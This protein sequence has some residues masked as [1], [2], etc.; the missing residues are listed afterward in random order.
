MSAKTASKPHQF[1][2]PEEY[3][4]P[5]Q[6]QVKEVFFRL[7]LMPAGLIQYAVERVTII[8]D[9]VVAREVVTERDILAITLSKIE[10]ELLRQVRR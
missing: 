10:D 5:E 9:Q 2:K 1:K 6:P 7:R 4:A 3:A 8:D